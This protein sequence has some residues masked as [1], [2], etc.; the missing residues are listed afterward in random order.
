MGKKQK[1]GVKTREGKTGAR[2]FC[3]LFNDALS[4]AQYVTPNGKRID[5]R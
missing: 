3:K 5:E 4:I 2:T 1:K